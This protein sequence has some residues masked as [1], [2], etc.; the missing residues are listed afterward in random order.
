MEGDRRARRRSPGRAAQETL[1][2]R[3][4]DRGGARRGRSLMTDGARLLVE[5]RA[6][7]EEGVCPPVETIL[8]DLPQA[9]N[10]LVLDL[11]YNEI[12]LREERGQHPSLE[13]Y[14]SRF[15]A[16]AADL[17]LQ[18]EV[19]ETI[20][21]PRSSSEKSPWPEVPGYEIKSVLGRGG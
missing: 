19:H 13:E 18:F 16:H 6:R 2:R 7:W 3:R 5:Q 4:R 15:P 17:R 8:K 9:S 20:R 21:R 14:A 10:E 12:V 1:A 11:I